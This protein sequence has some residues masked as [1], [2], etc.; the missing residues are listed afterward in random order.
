[1]LII[2]FAV[3]PTVPAEIKIDEAAE[4]LV[5]AAVEPSPVK[6]VRE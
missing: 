5:D 3:A 1:M 2:A 6:R 4:F